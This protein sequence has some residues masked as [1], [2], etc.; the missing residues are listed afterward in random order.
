MLTPEKKGIFSKYRL[1][2]IWG[3]IVAQGGLLLIAGLLLVMVA[4]LV[5]VIG[6]YIGFHIVESPGFCGTMCHSYMKYSYE[7][8][9]K[10]DH[11]GVNCGECHYEP[12]LKGFYEGGVKGAVR[13]MWIYY[14]TGDYEEPYHSTKILPITGESCK[15]CHTE[16]GLET[17][18]TL[19]KTVAFSHD[20][21]L[22][23]RELE[24][25]TGLRVKCTVCHANDEKVHMKEDTSL[26]LLCH[27]GDSERLALSCLDCHT[28]P[29]E[30]VYEGMRYNH[31]DWNESSRCTV[32]HQEMGRGKAEVVRE[33]CV[34]CHDD[35]FLEDHFPR[36]VTDARDT[37]RM[38]VGEDKARCLECHEGIR[39]QTERPFELKCEL[40]HLNEKRMYE[41][42]N[43]FGTRVSPS[44]MVTEAEMSCG[45]CHLKE[46]KY[47]PQESGCRDCHEEGEPNRSIKECQ[48]QYQ[49]MV[50]ELKVLKG[51]VE[52]AL[53][54]AEAEDRDIPE[55]RILFDQAD[56]NLK[57]VEGD[58]SAGVHNLTYCETLLAGAKKKLE[59]AGKELQR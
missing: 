34:F 42:I 21:H 41:G 44:T 4:V 11:H 53:R 18:E 16:E 36:S 57:I 49:L 50:S 6:G 12:G 43:V 55:A 32:C 20:H 13:E 5:L 9:E 39:H 59:Q 1:L 46:N 14:V 54:E 23:D 35:Q 58:V 52:K 29:P 33:S 56:F 19:F 51:K 3:A 40:C 8:W 31:P 28:S 47:R 27:M 17:K 26:C 37:H 15:R 24:D 10:S 38:H 22:S 48:A 25:R 30:V 7:S 2:W 45:D